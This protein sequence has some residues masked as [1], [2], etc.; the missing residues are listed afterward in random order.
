MD[1]MNIREIY[2]MNLIILIPLLL[3]T[4]K[5]KIELGK[6]IVTWFFLNEKGVFKQY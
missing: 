6:K 3:G 5:N 1:N 4:T 2:I